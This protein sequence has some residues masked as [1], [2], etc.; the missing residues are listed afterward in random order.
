MSV[1]T[2]KNRWT[3]KNIGIILAVIG[4]GAT[5][6]TFLLYPDSA[7][8][9]IENTGDQG[10]NIIL[11]NSSNVT[12][13]ISEPEEIEL[14]EIEPEEIEPEEIEPEP[15]PE[16]PSEQEVSEQEVSEQEVSE[17]EINTKEKKPS[18]K[19]MGDSFR[20]ISAGGKEI[21]IFSEVT[22][23]EMIEGI[24]GKIETREFCIEAKV[25]NPFGRF[26]KID[27]TNQGKAILVETF[28]QCF[29][30]PS[31]VYQVRYT[32]TPQSGGNYT[33][34][35]TII[36]KDGNKIESIHYFPVLGKRI[37]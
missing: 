9:L 33:V 11:S 32:L 7:K 24:N 29:E 16:P 37:G 28:V 5:V 34:I 30:N 20:T 17:I 18:V 14:E 1:G 26:T 4:I 15:I 2:S 35:H 27:A 12:I 3:R 23:R 25:K 13:N 8:N 22:I 31:D 21:L 36:P 19:W 10:I 6:G